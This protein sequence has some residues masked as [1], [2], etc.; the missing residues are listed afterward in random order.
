M[1]YTYLLNYKIKLD[2]D[3]VIHVTFLFK[4]KQCS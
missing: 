3:D 4:V 1:P 2:Y